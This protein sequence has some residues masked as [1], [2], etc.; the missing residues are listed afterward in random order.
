MSRVTTAHDPWVGRQTVP[1]IEVA[2]AA[3]L[4]RY[5]LRRVEHSG[6]IEH[7]GRD[8]RGGRLMLTHDDALFLLRAA[9]VATAAGI[10]LVTMVRLLR[11]AGASLGPDGFMIPLP[12]SP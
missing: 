4:P 10:G 5:D 12:A 11:Q 8:G 3:G 7:A 9:L 1:V 2:R 6:L